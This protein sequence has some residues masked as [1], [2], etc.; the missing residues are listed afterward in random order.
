[1]KLLIGV[2][3]TF[4]HDAPN[5][6]LSLLKPSLLAALMFPSSFTCFHPIR[7]ADEVTS[8]QEVRRGN[9]LLNEILT[10]SLGVLCVGL[11]LHLSK[12]PCL[13]QGSFV[14]SIR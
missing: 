9:S 2:V 1:V 14:G 7:V 12:P 6:S 11:F 4:D 13:H 8:L 5:Q 10:R 3:F